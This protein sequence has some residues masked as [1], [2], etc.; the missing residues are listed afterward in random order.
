MSVIEFQTPDPLIIAF[1]TDGLTAYRRMPLAVVLP[2]TTEEV[3]KVLKFCDE[4]NVKI[5]ARGAGTSLSGGAI[6][7]EDAVVLAVTKMSKVLEIDFDN[8]FI[9]VQSGITNL[10][11]T[12][13]VSAEGFFYAPDPVCQKIETAARTGGYRQAT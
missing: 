3:S 9:K 5:V 12:D 4:N 1:E 13:A 6:P 11:I 8:R 7:Q 10:S 2:E